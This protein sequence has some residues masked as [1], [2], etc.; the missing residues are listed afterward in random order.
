LFELLV[1]WAEAHCLIRSLL[2]DD[3]CLLSGEEA[4]SVLVAH[5]F[6]GILRASARSE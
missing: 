5:W 4:Y 3:A 6:V 2:R 1:Q